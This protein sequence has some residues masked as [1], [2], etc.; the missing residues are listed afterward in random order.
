MI[1]D[2]LATVTDPLATDDGI[3]NAEA[4]PTTPAQDTTIATTQGD[5]MNFETITSP[6]KS[7]RVNWVTRTCKSY[8]E[9]ISVET[10]RTHTLIHVTKKTILEN[11]FNALTTLGHQ[12]RKKRFTKK[13]DYTLR[14]FLAIAFAACPAL[15]I[16]TASYILPIFVTAFPSTVVFLDTLE[17]KTILQVRS[18]ARHAHGRT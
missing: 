11:A 18:L 13:A 9:L 7:R 15:A 6:A 10:P 1:T 5:D 12:T 14:C 8:G 17:M 3:N 16:T 4:A 2:L